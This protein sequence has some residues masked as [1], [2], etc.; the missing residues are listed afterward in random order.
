MLDFFL[1]APE[2]HTTL[3]ESLPQKETIFPAPNQLPGTTK[4]SRGIN[5]VESLHWK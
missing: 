3:S 5:V 2:Q 1:T 4:S